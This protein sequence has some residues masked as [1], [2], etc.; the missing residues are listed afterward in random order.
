MEHHL[1]IEESIRFGWEKTRQHSKIIFQTLLTLFGV[2]IAE[3]IVMRV[4]AN[5][6]DGALASAVLFVLAV[7]L[8][9]GFTFIMLRIAQGKHV[10]YADIIPTIRT[11]I[12]YIGATVLAGIV[13]VVPLIVALVVCLVA[14]AVLPNTAAMVVSAIVVAAAFVTAA[15]FALRYALV[16]FA[17]LDDNDI[18]KSLRTSAHLT[19]G[20]KWW[21]LGFAITIGLLNILGAILLLVG[22]LVTIP[23][24]M[25][26][27]SHVYVKLQ[28]HHS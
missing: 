21:L 5:T 8:G 11:S 12:A 16:R 28:A 7:V 22:L 9:I 27:L 19:E 10:V 3:Q 23:I 18:I 15:Y 6:L 4:L 13:T 2:Q 1:S 20:R 26:A 17:I 14:F 25:F 24:T